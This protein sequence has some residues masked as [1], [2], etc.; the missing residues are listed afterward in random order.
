MISNDDSNVS[1]DDPHKLGAPPRFFTRLAR[2]LLLHNSLFPP[3]SF[4]NLL[5]LYC[6]YQF[7]DLA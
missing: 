5:F 3:E 1:D 2:D 6:K 4:Q 7:Y